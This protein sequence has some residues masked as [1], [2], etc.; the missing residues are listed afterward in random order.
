MGI[1]LHLCLCTSPEVHL[2]IQIENDI[3]YLNQHDTDDKYVLLLG[4]F[5]HLPVSI[6]SLITYS[7]S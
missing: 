4:V 1:N 7:M 5:D 2:Y 3:Q 6:G